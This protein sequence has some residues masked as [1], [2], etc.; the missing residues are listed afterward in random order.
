MAQVTTGDEEQLSRLT[1]PF[2]SDHHLQPL[3][4][5]YPLR[6]IRKTQGDTRHRAFSAKLGFV[7]YAQSAMHSR[8]DPSCVPNLGALYS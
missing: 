1:I 7:E 4:P 5:L 2:L 3:R 6:A 8:A